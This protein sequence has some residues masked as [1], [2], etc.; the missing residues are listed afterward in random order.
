MQDIGCLEYK[1]IR[2]S[3]FVVSPSGRDFIMP[4]EMTGGGLCARN[5]KIG[6]AA[7]NDKRD[8]IVSPPLNLASNLLV[9]PSMTGLDNAA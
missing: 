9:L 1:V 8:V 3:R 6:D 2:I 5:D 4:L 7:R